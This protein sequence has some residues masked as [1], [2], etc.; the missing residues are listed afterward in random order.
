MNTHIRSAVDELADQLTLGRC[1]VG[2]DAARAIAQRIEGEHGFWDYEAR[3]NASAPQAEPSLP[4]RP[5]ELLVVQQ[6]GGESR[7]SP[8]RARPGVPAGT[9]CKSAETHPA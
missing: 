5:D 3:K 2:P 6:A 4:V 8:R 1:Y 7:P 9:R